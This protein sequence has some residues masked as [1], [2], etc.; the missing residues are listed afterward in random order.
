M[1]EWPFAEKRGLPDCEVASVGQRFL[2]VFASSLS[3][4]SPQRLWI[5]E[6]MR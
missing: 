3:S 1:L 5:G 2:E 4:P 6:V